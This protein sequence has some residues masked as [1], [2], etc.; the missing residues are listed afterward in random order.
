MADRCKRPPPLLKTIAK[1]SRSAEEFARRAEAWN[2]GEAKPMSLACLA[3]AY[4]RGGAKMTTLLRNAAEQRAEQRERHWTRMSKGLR[5]LRGR[6][7]APQ[8]VDVRKIFAWAPKVE[9]TIVDVAEGRTSR[10]T[11]EPVKVSRLDTP[12]GGYWIVDGHHRVVEAA[13][14]GDSTIKVVVDEHLPRVERT[15]GAYKSVLDN[16]VNVANRV[17]GRR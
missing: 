2:A 1:E 11:H 14:R 5:G 3:K 16:R 6:K 13:Q 17:R 7:L 8:S 10:S 15:G 4:R 12:R 9:E